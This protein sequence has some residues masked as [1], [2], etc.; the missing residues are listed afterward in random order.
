M[1]RGGN[2][3]SETNC[4][5][6]WNCTGRNDYHTVDTVDDTI[7]S[8]PS[9]K[10][11]FHDHSSGLVGKV[12]GVNCELSAVGKGIARRLA[13]WGKGQVTDD[14]CWR[15]R[16]D[17]L[18]TSGPL[19]PGSHFSCGQRWFPGLS[20]SCSAAAGPPS[21]SCSCSSPAWYSS[22][23]PSLQ[24]SAPPYFLT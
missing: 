11:Q 10:V 21:S 5:L 2:M 24:R 14:T 13:G 19:Q 6:A 8:D 12:L 23:T 7:C 22:S 4:T 18:P 20:W 3:C 9:C 16:S 15:T 1:Y 17:Y